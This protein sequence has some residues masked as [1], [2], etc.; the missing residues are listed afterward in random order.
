MSFS[1]EFAAEAQ[2][3][4]N[5]L[6]VVCEITLND[7]TWNVGSDT[8]PAL[9]TAMN[10][11]DRAVRARTRAYDPRVVRGG[12]TGLRQQI[13][14]R[15][16]GLSGYATSVTVGDPDN[17][18]RDALLNGDNRQSAAV[19]LRVVPGSD[20]D[21]DT[22]FT[23]LLDS[24]EFMTG[25]VRLNLKTDERNLRAHFPAWPYLKSEWFQMDPA[26]D[27]S[28]AA[29]VYGKHDSTALNLNHGMVPTVPVWLGENS[30]RATN[31]GPA[32][33]IKDVYVTA[34]TTVTKQTDTTD[35]NKVYGSLA[36]GKIFTIVEFINFPS[37]DTTV[38]ADLYG[39]PLTTPG[40]FTGADVITNPVTQLR[41]FLVNF[42]ANRTRGYITGAWDMTDN[43]L[44]TASWDAAAT[45][46]NNHGLE[47]SRFMTDQATALSTIR[48]WCESFPMFRP[49]W[50]TAGK[51]EMCV[52]SAEWPGYWDGT[53]PMIRREDT[54]GSAFQYRLDSS[55]I[56]SKISAAYL[57]D[58]VDNKFLRMLDVEDPTTGEL[59]D[60]SMQ[61]F[62]APSRQT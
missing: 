2:A 44:D 16:A 14:L 50:N 23:G 13:E 43:L 3:N 6:A 28:Y 15:S 25:Q 47:G 9:T 49:F 59:E 61:M 37:T 42:A 4:P 10:L 30:W 22:R 20:D 58:S 35:Y 36:G 56:T 39:Y 19:I 12:W 5:D 48:E 57:R 24:W 21:Y 55:D 34:S 7:A 62:W 1:G 11:S 17:R 41:H 40:V 38:T 52:L 53:S 46:A 31:I 8:V 18:V 51:V 27:R 60:T 29:I 54:I 45:W 26:F 32:S 33:Y